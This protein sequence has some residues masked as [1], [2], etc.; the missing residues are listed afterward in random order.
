[1]L[2]DL[3]D[4]KNYKIDSFSRVNI[5]E[6]SKVNSKSMR[7]N[8]V[9]DHWQ[10]LNVFQNLFQ[11]ILLFKRN[12]RDKIVQKR[13]HKNNGKRNRVY[14][15][16]HKIGRRTFLRN[17]NRDKNFENRLYVTKIKL[18]DIN[19][20]KYL[21]NNQ[22]P[23]YIAFSLPSNFGQSKTI[24]EMNGEITCGPGHAMVVIGYD[25]SKKAFQLMNSW[26]DWGKMVQDL[27]G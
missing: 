7:Q 15:K 6:I 13:C 14:C 17:G 22:N 25:D 4:A 21:V 23:L 2:L 1:M 11:K 20:I 12:K 8:I 18:S 27:V 3:N 26:K 10:E 5:G 16:Y 9:C 24:I 19:Y